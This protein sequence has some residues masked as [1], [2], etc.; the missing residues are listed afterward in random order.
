MTLTW[1]DTADGAL[2]ERGLVLEQGRRGARR[3]LRVLPAEQDAWSPRQAEIELAELGPA[4]TPAEAEDAP[5]VPIAAFDGRRTLIPMQGGVQAELLAGRLRAVADDRPAARLS[6]AGPP[7]A[8]AEAVLALAAELPL[9]PPRAALAEDGRALS[10]GESTRPARLGAP[11]LQDAPTVEDALAATIDHLTGVLIWFAPI[12]EAGQ[13]PT[14]V[15]QMRVACRRLRSALRAFRPAADG[16]AL[17]RFDAEIRDL[18]AVLG[19]ARDWDVWLGGLGAELVDTLPDDKRIGR[20]LRAA[21]AKRQAAYAALRATLAGAPFRAMIWHGTLLAERRPWRDE[22]PEGAPLR[23]EALAEFAAGVV[24]KRWKKLVEA[25]TD[26]GELPDEEFHELRLDGK[27][28]RY[29]A[30]LFAPLWARKRGRRFLKL[31]ASVQEEFGL[32]NDTSAARGLVSPLAQEGGAGMAWAVG[33]AE[34][35]A[36]ARGRRARGRAANAWAELMQAEP[37]WD[38]R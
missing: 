20:L 24:E 4:E 27:R 13:D 37:F 16:A 9:L 31:L 25:G 36:L 5:L 10:R 22:H 11:Q 30:E 35:W 17:R 26:I 23:A 33:V 18:A 7:A 29:V 14:G 6:L 15:H 2:A 8:V 19:P 38:Q 12:A 34:G 1:L 21:Q 28:M 32:A 3:L